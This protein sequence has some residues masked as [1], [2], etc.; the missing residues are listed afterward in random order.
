MNAGPRARGGVREGRKGGERWEGRMEGRWR[1][2][3]GKMEGCGVKGKELQVE[4]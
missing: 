3:V 1:R 2:E 4:S